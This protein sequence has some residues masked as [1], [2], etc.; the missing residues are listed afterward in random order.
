MGNNGRVRVPLCWL[1]KHL[2]DIEDWKCT[3]FPKGIPED[4][5]LCKHNHYEPYRGD[6]GIQ[7]EMI[8]LTLGNRR[9]FSRIS[10]ELKAQYLIERGG[11][12]K[13]C[14]VTDVSR[15]GMGITFQTSEKI[16]VGTTIHLKI[17]VPTESTPV[18]AKGVL[19][20]IEEKGNN[21]IG[22]IKWYKINRG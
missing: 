18:N 15:E 12:W 20:W 21:F 1:C 4:I 9:R 2:H 6:N 5:R 22:G 17:F 16:N 19:K 11:G 13:K 7:F 14:K 3:A 10:K 8:D